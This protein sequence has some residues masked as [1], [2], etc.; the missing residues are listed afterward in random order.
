[1]RIVVCVKQVPDTMDVKID[2]T[3]NNLQRSSVGGTINPSDK[4]AVAIALKLKEKTGAEIVVISMGP[5]QAAAE[6]EKCLSWGADSAYL[7][8]DRKFVGA[9]TLATS[10]TLADF[11]KT[12]DADIVLCGAE[13]VDG[14]TG[15]V[16]P[17]IGERMGLPTITYVEDVDVDENKAIVR[18][19][20]GVY[21]ETYSVELPFIACI[22][23]NDAN[24]EKVNDD[25]KDITVV[26]ADSFDEKTIGSN[27]SPTKVVT[28]SYGKKDNDYLWVDYKW[29]LE[30][31]MEFIF[32]GG[33]EIKEYNLIK[34]SPEDSA[35]FILDEIYNM[36]GEE[37]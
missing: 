8:S 23:K 15:Q 36:G 26:N 24:P 22:L 5:P 4:S 31:R 7:L 25:K 21:L 33:L 19:N 29:D 1:M 30:K 18:R 35:G 3:T 16:G 17:E 32:N 27:G 12:L 2:P 9:D 28:I 34:S 13:A 10:R 14:S 20:T 6:L 11:I 37:K